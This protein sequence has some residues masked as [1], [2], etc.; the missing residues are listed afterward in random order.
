MSCEDRSDVG[1]VHEA[2]L[3]AVLY[4]CLWVAWGADKRVIDDDRLCR[5]IPF[6]ERDDR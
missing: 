6:R 3:L 2:A 5:E 1:C 4:V